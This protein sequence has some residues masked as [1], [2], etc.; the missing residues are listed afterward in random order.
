MIVDK[1]LVIL[2]ALILGIIIKLLLLENKELFS[3]IIHI[4]AIS[5]FI[6]AIIQFVRFTGKK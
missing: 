6:I 4:I 1:I 5:G 3:T 2:S